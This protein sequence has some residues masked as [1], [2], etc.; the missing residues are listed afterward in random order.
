MLKL[1]SQRTVVTV[2]DRRAVLV[3]VKS[4]KPKDVAAVPNEAFIRNM[5]KDRMGWARKEPA[6][7]TILAVAKEM[8]A[9]VKAAADAAWEAGRPKREALAALKALEAQAKAAAEEVAS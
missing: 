3:A 8:A 7:A 9:A 5:L 6:P 2:D 1:Q 4:R